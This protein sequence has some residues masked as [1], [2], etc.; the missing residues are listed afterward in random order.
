MLY[1]HTEAGGYGESVAIRYEPAH[2][3]ATFTACFT[4]LMQLIE[5]PGVSPVHLDT[6]RL[7]EIA[8]RYHK[9][10]ALDLGTGT[11]YVAIALAKA[12]AEV[13]ATDITDA[14]LG[15]AR[16]N[17]EKEGV[18]VNVFRSDLF[19]RTSAAYD[20]IVFNPPIGGA[21][22]KWQARLKALIRR[23]PLKNVA[24]RLLSRLMQRKR[25]PFLKRVIDEALAHLTTDGILLL[26]VQ[27]IDIPALTSHPIRTIEAV[28]EHS[29][30]V[31]IR[32]A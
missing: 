12:G 15:C 16:E 26:H 18:R 5:R 22:P 11:G 7:A 29:S 23:S 4:C 19:E 25:L 3:D 32:K 24:S 21:E 20:L 17:A 2:V 31:E 10:R 8:L 14:A 30:I 6:V 27:S 9:H 13:D 28:F 1:R